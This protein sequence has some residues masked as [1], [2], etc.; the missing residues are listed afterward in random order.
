MKSP[1]PQI[2]LRSIVA[3][4]LRSQRKRASER[5]LLPPDAPR[6]LLEAV[7]RELLADLAEASHG[8]RRRGLW[9]FSAPV[10]L[11]LY[12]QALARLLERAE[13]KG[14]REGILVASDPDL[15]DQCACRCR[16]HRKTGCRLCLR[17]EACPAHGDEA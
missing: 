9:I 4:L 10:D 8:E 7:G 14:R 2:D 3:R 13:E 11:E 5:A 12:A 16:A 15:D 6:H 17:T 1:V